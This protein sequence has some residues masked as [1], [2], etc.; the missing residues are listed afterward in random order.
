MDKLFKPWPAENLSSL[1]EIARKPVIVGI[2]TQVT[3]GHCLFLI[4]IL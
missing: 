3:R 2:E 1:I 4:E